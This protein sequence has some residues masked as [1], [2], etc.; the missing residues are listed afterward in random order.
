MDEK[1]RQ[2]NVSTDVA[3]SSRLLHHNVKAC[4]YYVTKYNVKHCRH[5]YISYVGVAN[6]SLCMSRMS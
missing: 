1:D 3:A 2:H 6:P 5:H 4:G